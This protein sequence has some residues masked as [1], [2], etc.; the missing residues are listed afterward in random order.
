MD[1]V[2]N[3]RL[4]SNRPLPFLT[5]NVRG[6]LVNNSGKSNITVHPHQDLANGSTFS[7]NIA[8]MFEVLRTQQLPLFMIDEEV[9]IVSSGASPRADRH[10]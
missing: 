2:R 5:F 3:V 8:D 6:F 1:D 10:L 7:I 4:T 9:S